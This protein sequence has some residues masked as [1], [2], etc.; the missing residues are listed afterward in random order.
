MALQPTWYKLYN[1]MYNY[2]NTITIGTTKITSHLYFKHQ[3]SVSYDVLSIYNTPLQLAANVKSTIVS[4]S[5]Q[6][7][8]VVTHGFLITSVINYWL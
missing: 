4:H 6:D 7:Y 3:D 8:L 1:Y 5:Q 2:T